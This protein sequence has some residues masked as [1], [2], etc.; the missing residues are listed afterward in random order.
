MVQG[1]D[2]MQASEEQAQ[3]FAG[4]TEKGTVIVGAVSG[5]F[6]TQAEGVT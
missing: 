1:R 3:D 2:H 6:A 5:H 4:T